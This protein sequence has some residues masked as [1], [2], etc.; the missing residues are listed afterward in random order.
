MFVGEGIS[1]LKVWLDRG[2]EHFQVLR[3]VEVG[4]HFPC[5]KLN[6]ESKACLAIA[7]GQNVLHIGMFCDDTLETRREDFLPCDENEKIIRTTHDPVLFVIV[8]VGLKAI[9]DNKWFLPTGRISNQAVRIS[10]V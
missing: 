7:E 3:F 6:K 9:L 5:S 1:A 4:L 10:I 2:E 8:R